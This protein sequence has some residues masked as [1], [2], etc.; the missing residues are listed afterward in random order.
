MLNWLL[1]STFACSLLDVKLI[2]SYVQETD[3]GSLKDV[4]DQLAT[5]PARNYFVTVFTCV[6]LAIFVIGMCCGRITKRIRLEM[7]A[8]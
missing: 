4:Y 7:K 2:M 3:M 6:V 1:L 8:K 5:S